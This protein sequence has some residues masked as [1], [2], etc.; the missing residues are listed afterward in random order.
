MTVSR[1]KMRT[2]AWVILT[3]LW[4]VTTGLFLPRTPSFGI[5][6][7]LIAVPV[8]LHVLSSSLKRLTK[9][10]GDTSTERQNPNSNNAK[11]P[12]WMYFA[13]PI[14][15]SLKNVAQ[16]FLPES[17]LGF[18][19]LSVFLGWPLF[20]INLRTG[21]CFHRSLRQ[22]RAL[23]AALATSCIGI[24]GGIC[25]YSFRQEQ[26]M[27]LFFLLL[28]ASALCAVTIEIVDTRL[29]VKQQKRD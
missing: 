28:L 3:L 23:L 20:E 1:I 11:V 8:V 12:T 16:A 26:V 17:F 21:V 25:I 2:I 14:G 15:L 5:V 9:G 29:A 6:V 18:V 4:S 19:T 13:V 27:S 7:L 24:A 10:T 22:S